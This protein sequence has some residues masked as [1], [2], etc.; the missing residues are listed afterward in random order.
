MGNHSVEPVRCIHQSQVRGAVVGV[1]RGGIQQPLYFAQDGETLLHLSVAQRPERCSD[2]V[3]HGQQQQLPHCSA[4]RPKW[5]LLQ[6][7]VLL[8]HGFLH[9]RHVENCLDKFTNSAIKLGL[10]GY[11][12][13]LLISAMICLRRVRVVIVLTV[14]VQL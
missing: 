8:L 3:N 5:H 6:V 10:S 14:H 4:N 7:N 13:L 2:R 1:E 9:H 12:V 11:F